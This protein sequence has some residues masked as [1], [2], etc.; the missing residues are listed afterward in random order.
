MTDLSGSDWTTK[1]SGSCAFSAWQLQSALHYIQGHMLEP[2]NQIN[3]FVEVL[4][5]SKLLVLYFGMQNCGILMTKSPSY[6][7]NEAVTPSLAFICHLEIMKSITVFLVFLGFSYV[8]SASVISPR[9][10]KPS[11]KPPTK[12]CSY[13][14]Q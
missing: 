3:Y 12:V 2:P 10:V 13:Y 4:G 6:I 7:Y 14:T 1:F 8:L 11:Y 5:I 9:K